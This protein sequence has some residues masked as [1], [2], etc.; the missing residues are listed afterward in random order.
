MEGNSPY[1]RFAQAAQQNVSRAP[2]ETCSFCTPLVCG[3]HF[4]ASELSLIGF[5]QV[6]QRVAGSMDNARLPLAPTDEI[7]GCGTNVVP[8]QGVKVTAFRRAS[9]FD[10]SAAQ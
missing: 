9:P 6:S 8:G 2:P 10:V 4:G 3:L 5:S 1:A 7:Q